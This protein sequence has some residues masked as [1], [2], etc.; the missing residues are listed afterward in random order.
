MSGRLSMPAIERFLEKVEVT[1]AGCW[2]WTAAKTGSTHRYGAFVWNGQQSTAH[3]FAYEFW[4]GPI[5][6][7]M[8]V[9]HLCRTPPCVNPD[10]LEV[11]SQGEN[12]LRGDT[13]PA[14][15]AKKTECVRG[16]PFDLFNTLNAANGS[17]QCRTCK[18][19]RQRK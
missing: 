10:H 8:S 9:D 1:K 12:I 11:V 2:L 19:E 15:N 14:F 16:H 6:E 17:R 18:R 13:L 5:A 7:G 3:R 4:R